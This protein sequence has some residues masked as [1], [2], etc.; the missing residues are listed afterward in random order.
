MSRIN[1]INATAEDFKI[2]VLSSA[3][4]AGS[5]GDYANGRIVKYLTHMYLWC[6]HTGEWI[7]FPNQQ[8]YANAES[9]ISD[10]ESEQQ[11]R[12][13]VKTWSKA[14]KPKKIIVIM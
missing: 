10:Q 11:L 13:R 12:D 4:S 7:K 9:S 6:D 1:I 3:P 8:D 14:A 2:E 5:V